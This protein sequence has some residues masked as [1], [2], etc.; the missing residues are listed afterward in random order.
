MLGRI[1]IM[2]EIIYAIE[3]QNGNQDLFTGK[4]VPKIPP[5]NIVPMDKLTIAMT[6]F[7][8]QSLLLHI[9][10]PDPVIR[11]TL[12]HIWILEPERYAVAVI[13]AKILSSLVYASAHP[14]VL[15]V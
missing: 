7:A 2:N 5:I 8:L 9:R 13:G 10:S 12:I 4:P 11:I 14:E 3:N 15:N 6:T 1:L